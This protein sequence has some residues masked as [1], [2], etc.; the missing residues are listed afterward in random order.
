LTQG[1]LV[2]LHLVLLQ[3]LP[4]QLRNA[5][6]L[7]KCHLLLLLVAHRLLLLLAHNF[8][9]H[10]IHQETS[11]IVF[12]VCCTGQLHCGWSIDRCGRY[13]C[14]KQRIP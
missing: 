2:S 11:L 6:S 10:G 5:L 14:H 8:E 3:Q 1:E 7:K 4:F 12:H 9:S 13:P